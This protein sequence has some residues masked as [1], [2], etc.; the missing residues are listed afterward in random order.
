MEKDKK[1]MKTKYTEKIPAHEVIHQMVICDNPK[2]QSVIKDN[3]EQ[4]SEL[5]IQ[6]GR[7]A[8]RLLMD[9][10]SDKCE[11]ASKIKVSNHALR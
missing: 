9:F 6:S 2:C 5:H 11:R 1:E 7:G 10:C 8:N 3:G 4:V